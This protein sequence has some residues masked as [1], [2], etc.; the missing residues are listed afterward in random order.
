MRTCNLRHS[1][2][3]GNCASARTPP[4]EEKYH[5]SYGS[6]MEYLW[7]P[8]GDPMEQHGSTTGAT[9]EQLANRSSIRSAVAG[10]A[11]RLRRMGLSGES[12]VQ[13]LAGLRIIRL[14]SQG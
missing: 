9:R 12:G 8:Y 2:A 4:T 10:S 6:P 1:P 13:I 3:N 14:E 5:H 7:K 11:G